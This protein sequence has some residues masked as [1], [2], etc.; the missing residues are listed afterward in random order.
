MRTLFIIITNL[1]L[2]NSCWTKHSTTNSSIILEIN[3]QS[4]LDSVD[5]TKIEITPKKKFWGYIKRVEVIR[6]QFWIK[7]ISNVDFKIVAIKSPCDC[8]NIDYV[9]D[10]IRPCDSLV[11][12]YSIRVRKNETMV[13]QAIIVIGN[14]EYGNQTF[15]TEA[16]INP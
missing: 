4:S 16:Y 12:K 15:Y 9:G 11:V 5:K 6:D 7:N 13:K 10:I 1:I 14:C 3:K 8:V 2:L